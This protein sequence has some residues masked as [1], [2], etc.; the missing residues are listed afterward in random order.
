ML[1]ISVVELLV[2]IVVLPLLGGVIGYVVAS[3][4]DKGEDH[5]ERAWRSRVGDQLEWLLGSQDGSEKPGY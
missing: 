1:S 3:D 5:S 2:M 4:R